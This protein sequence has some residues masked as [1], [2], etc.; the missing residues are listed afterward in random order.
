MNCY[1]LV[2]AGVSQYW[3][4]SVQRFV[5]FFAALFYFSFFCRIGN[6][7]LTLGEEF[8]NGLYNTKW[9]EY[10][11]KCQKMV[12]LILTTSKLRDGI[13]FGIR[14]A[15]SYELLLTVLKASYTYLNLLLKSR[16]KIIES[17]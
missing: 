6:N 8:R 10:D 16:K 4:R 17:R 3:N 12:L 11:I 15:A 14:S 7:L 9:Y 1:F 5:G 13:T 2:T